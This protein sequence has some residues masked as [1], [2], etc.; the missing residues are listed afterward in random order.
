[1]LE[2]FQCH[3]L[4]RHLLDRMVLLLGTLT[5]QALGHMEA[6]HNPNMEPIA[7]LACNPQLRSVDKVPEPEHNHLTARRIHFEPRQD[8]RLHPFRD[9][10]QSARNMWGVRRTD[11]DND[12]DGVGAT[13]GVAARRVTQR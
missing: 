2:Q 12:I 1:M 11:V 6:I 13:D 9:R 4:V 5:E 8:C 7:Q 3:G 10:L